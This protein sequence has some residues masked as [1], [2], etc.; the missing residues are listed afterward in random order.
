MSHVALKNTKEPNQESKSETFEATLREAF[1]NVQRR[2]PWLYVGETDIVQGW[3]IHLSSVPT[4]ACNLIRSVS[5]LLSKH[6]VSFKVAQDSSTLE[7]LNEGLL[8]PTQI[9]KFMTIY[10]NND[11]M[12]RTL[13]EALIEA[14]SA[15]SGPEIVTDMCL[16]QITYA[17]YGAFNP[18]QSRDRLGQLSLLIHDPEGGLATDA[19]QVPFVS[20][21]N[22]PN[23]FQG[24]ERLD[25]PLAKAGG[26]LFAERFLLVDVLKRHP[27][28]SVFR[29]IDLSDP[30]N[31]RAIVLKE[32]RRHCS[33]DDFGRDMRLRLQHQQEL[34]Q[35]LS[36]L[37][38]VPRAFGYFEYRGHGYLPLE[39]LAGQSLAATF[40]APWDN[41]TQAER[42]QVLKRFVQVAEMVQSLH[43]SGYIH[44]DLTIRNI[45]IGDDDRVYLLDFEL[46]QPI[47]SQVPPYALGTP[48]FMSPAQ[49]QASPTCQPADD[50]YALGACLTFFLTGFDP[51]ALEHQRASHRENQ[52]ARLAATA[53]QPL[54]T[55][56]ASCLAD[57]AIARPDITSIISVLTTCSRQ[58]ETAQSTSQPPMNVE[59]D[60]LLRQGVRALHHQSFLSSHQDLWFSA[61]LDQPNALCHYRS[62][63]RGVAGVIYCLARLAR[64]GYGDGMDLQRIGRAVSWL[65]DAHEAPDAS[66]PGLY[67]GDAGVAVSVL[68]AQSAGLLTSFDDLNPWLERLLCGSLDWPDLTHGAAGQG[69]AGLIAS[70]HHANTSGA[71]Q[72]HRAARYLVDHQRADGSFRFPEGVQDM[73][74]AAY[75][76]FA[77]GAAGII[78]FLASYVERFP[79]AAVER[80]YRQATEWLMANAI[81]KNIDDPLQWSWGSQQPTIWN[82][83]CHGA[84]GIALAFLRLFEVT[85]ETHWAKLAEQSLAIPAGHLRNSNLGTCH[86]IAG[87][88]EIFLEAARVLE[89]DRWNQAASDVAAILIALQGR[90]AGTLSWQVEGKLPTADLMVGLSGVLHFLLRFANGRFGFPLLLEAQSL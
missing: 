18:I 50:I 20:P 4:Q 53:P 5:P 46:A 79:D 12:A 74:G 83:W 54:R 72:A 58:P 23:P 82:W 42:R 31:V 81:R 15:F 66:L 49:K 76:G 22:R 65:R 73:Q 11:A 51:S 63:S 13:A 43:L 67:F 61:S 48:G 40:H 56:I 68:E 16:G 85:G 8:G 7:Q 29:G 87:L 44:R 24:L 25:Q 41:C 86:G 38:F 37:S 59:I 27:K 52:L 45:W 62:A 36:H 78:Y 26:S 69:L 30:D 14:T 80:S 34:H 3:K 28:G 39:Y 57:E 55:M 9:G 32:G 19:Y 2:H 77:H 21:S 1:D 84:P 35:K 88:G 75:F 64:G 90:S 47:D 10:P 6:G 33:S 60:D 89:N 17:R 70:D 71:Q